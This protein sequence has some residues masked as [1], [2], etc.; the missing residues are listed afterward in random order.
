MFVKLQ[1]SEDWNMGLL[2]YMKVKALM[3]TPWFLASTKTTKNF[4][5]GDVFYYAY[6]HTLKVIDVIVALHNAE[7]MQQPVFAIDVASILINL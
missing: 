5:I 3:D 7:L 4:V 2:Q 1:V 6:E